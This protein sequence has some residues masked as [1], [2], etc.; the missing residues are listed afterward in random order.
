MLHPQCR[1]CC[2]G[3]GV[4]LLM[5]NAERRM[6]NGGESFGK[7][8]PIFRLVNKDENQYQT[9]PKQV[10]ADIIRLLIEI[11]AEDNYVNKKL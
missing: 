10:G 3:D 5:Q 1:V 9:L 6:Q 2:V 11:F 8:E 4:F 7:Q